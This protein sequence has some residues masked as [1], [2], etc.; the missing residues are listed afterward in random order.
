MTHGLFIL[1]EVITR[2]SLT[3]HLDI[4]ISDLVVVRV[5]VGGFV[6]EIEAVSS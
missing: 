3:H 6:S 5:V 1:C 2:V 4:L